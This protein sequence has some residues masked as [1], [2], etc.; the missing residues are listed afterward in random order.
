ME[1]FSANTGR[2]C[3]YSFGDIKSMGIEPKNTRMI[4]LSEKV[5]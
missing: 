3:Y 5:T 4:C 2:A 1:V